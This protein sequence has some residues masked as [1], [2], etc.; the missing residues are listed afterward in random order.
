ML[1]LCSR[2]ERRRGTTTWSAMIRLSCRSVCRGT[3]VGD[4]PAVC[5]VVGATVGGTLGSGG[6][7]L[8]T[9]FR[10][11]GTLGC[12]AGI[13]LRMMTVAGMTVSFWDLVVEVKSE[14]R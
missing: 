1:G 6:G 8:S 7:G 5:D 2:G 13:P 12:G 3:V 14:E 11:G 4:A 10:G 9:I